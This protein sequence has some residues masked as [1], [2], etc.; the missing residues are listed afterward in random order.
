MSPRCSSRLPPEI[1][2]SQ[3][4]SSASA[5]P[6]SSGPNSPAN[7]FTSRP[8]TL[9]GLSKSMQNLKS[10]SRRKSVHNIPLSPLARTPSPSPMTLSPTS[11]N[12][13][14][15][16][17][18]HSVKTGSSPSTLTFK[19]SPRLN[20]NSVCCSSGS[21]ER[22]TCYGSQGVKVVN[23]FSPS[24]HRSQHNALSK[25]ESS[26][27]DPGKVMPTKHTGGQSQRTTSCD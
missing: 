22:S 21:V 14:S 17:A 8:G 19:H 15:K 23:T 4:F 27:S 24:S 2:L 26:Q 25:T 1:G 5:S 11:H 18:V 6:L 16:L 12:P 20:K 10:P 3:S 7:S 9:Q 13:T